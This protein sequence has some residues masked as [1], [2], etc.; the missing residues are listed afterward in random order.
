ML[1]RAH[2]GNMTLRLIEPGK[3]NQNAYVESFNGRLRDDC[4]NDNWF[5][6][7]AHAQ[8]VIETGRREYSEQRPK[9]ALGGLT[10][11]TY[12]KQLA[13]KMVAVTSD[14]NSNRY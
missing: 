7:L 10:P 8:V 5:T 13:Q 3:P 9:K 6:S 12:A 1:M 14:S 2:Q 11:A 4:L